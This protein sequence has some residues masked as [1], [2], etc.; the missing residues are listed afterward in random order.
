MPR[1]NDHEREKRAVQAA[2]E[3]LDGTMT[4]GGRVTIARG[5]HKGSSGVILRYSPEHGK[6][7]VRLNS[8]RGTRAFAREALEQRV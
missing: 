8:G 1:S 3:V 2:K 7:T 4:M 6:Y 5:K